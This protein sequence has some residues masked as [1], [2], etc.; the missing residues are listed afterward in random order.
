MNGLK[1]AVLLCCFLVPLHADVIV[2]RNG[3]QMI[4]HGSYEVK[5]QYVVFQTEKK[6]TLQLPLKLVDIEKSKLAT[7]EL[8]AKL[9]AE[10]KARKEAE[11]LALNPP[12][13]GLTMAEIAEIVQKN[14]TGDNPMKENVT[15]GSDTLQNYSDDNPRPTQSE[16]EFAG[17]RGDTTLNANVRQQKAGE[18]AGAMA[19]LEKKENLLRQRAESLR[20]NIAAYDS[21]AFADG[22]TNLYEQGERARAE[23]QK[24]EAELEEVAKQKR[25]VD[26]Q[27]RKAGVK[28]YKR[29][30]KKM[31]DKN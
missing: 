27:A 10:E 16:A 31:G 15:I 21:T 18:F 29:I 3:K 6:E 11:Q 22:P 24:V 2:L 19:E 14:R 4:I 25:E 30:N 28:N 23:L 17:P 12:K 9:E 13:K 7:A 5:G 20:S 26:T 1:T 8:H